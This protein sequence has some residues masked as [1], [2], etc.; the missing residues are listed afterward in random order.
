MR[1]IYT[2]EDADRGK[3]VGFD[4]D[5]F[6]MLV[7]WGPDG[8]VHSESIQPFGSAIERPASRHYSDQTALFA[9][10]KFKPVRFDEAALAGHVERDYRP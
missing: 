7:E 3:R 4:G 6:V 1:A 8:K 5:S 10:E 9:A 2:H